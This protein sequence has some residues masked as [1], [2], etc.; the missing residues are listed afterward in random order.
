MD[1]IPMSLMYSDSSEDTDD[2][3]DNINM[4]KSSYLQYMDKQYNKGVTLDSNQ[5][6]M[7]SGNMTMVTKCVTKP[8]KK[9][10][11]NG[12]T[13]KNN[14]NYKYQQYEVI[15]KEINGAIERSN[16]YI[17][18]DIISSTINLYHHGLQKNQIHRGLVKKGCQA[19]CLYH[20][21]I[22]Y[23]IPMKPKE[24]AEIFEIQQKS[25]SKGISIINKLYY[26]KLIDENIMH[27]NTIKYKDEFID[28]YCY[29]IT[30]IYDKPKFQIYYS[31]CVQVQNYLRRY[32]DLMDL[33][34]SHNNNLFM[35][36]NLLIY[37]SMK[38]HIS[39]SSIPSSKCA[40]VIYLLAYSYN[41]IAT[42]DDIIN[43]C[44]ISKG[45]YQKFTNRI[46]AILKN[47]N[48]YGKLYKMIRHLYNKYDVKL[49][50]LK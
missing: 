41:D 6:F 27:P 35:F 32:F 14:E 4:N 29:K 17:K 49:P 30:G 15:K 26:M 40:A 28:M 37:L 9:K 39:D 1:Y 20:M 10:Y 50:N 25:I 48:K 23:N 47:K 5:P 2:E 31:D 19:A 38:K 7:I 3:S 24:I 11:I 36:C 42:E 18:R 33:D 13:G 46:L 21:C 43:Y 45:T 16:T 8:H 22:E 12:N 34:A 44:Q